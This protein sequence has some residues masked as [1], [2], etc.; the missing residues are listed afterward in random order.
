MYGLN[1]LLRLHFYQRLPSVVVAVHAYKVIAESEQCYENSMLP[2][3]L[4][5]RTLYT[6]NIGEAALSA[7][8]NLKYVCNRL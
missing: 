3:H 1:R 2:F 6:Q 8:L 7:H 5:P 4:F